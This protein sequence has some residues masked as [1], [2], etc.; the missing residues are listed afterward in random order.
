VSTATKNRLAKKRKISHNSG[1]KATLVASE[2]ARAAEELMANREAIKLTNALNAA[3]PLPV[4]KPGTSE[5]FSYHDDP[6]LTE[7]AEQHDA[8]ETLEELQAKIDRIQ[9]RRD[10][11]HPLDLPK[12][13][14]TSEQMEYIAE[15]LPAARWV[16]HGTHFEYHTGT[17]F[18]NMCQHYLAVAAMIDCATY[19]H[20][21]DSVDDSESS[22][23][24]DV[25]MDN[26]TGVKKDKVPIVST[27][28]AATLC[29][30]GEGK[31]PSTTNTFIA[32]DELVRSGETDSLAAAAL[33][34]V[35]APDAAVDSTF[36]H[37]SASD[38][39]EDPGC[40]DWRDTRTIDSLSSNGIKFVTIGRQKIL[41][42]HQR[43]HKVSTDDLGVSNNDCSCGPSLVCDLCE[44]A[45]AYIIVDD[46]H[47][48]HPVQI[49]EFLENGALVY[50]VHCCYEG[51]RGGLFTL[52]QCK[53]EI[54]Y[55][56]IADV[57]WLTSGRDSV[58]RCRENTDW[59]WGRS[60]KI[61][62]GAHLTWK[63]LAVAA[64]SYLFKF[65]L[66]E[67]PRAEAKPRDPFVD[68][69]Y[70][71]V[72]PIKNIKDIVD[73]TTQ[74]VLGR[75]TQLYSAGDSLCCR[76][77]DRY[78]YVPKEGIGHISLWATGRER[79]A[80]F[81]RDANNLAKQWLRATK[82][83]ECERADCVA[84]MVALGIYRN[85]GNEITALTELKP[86]T[87]ILEYNTK[88]AEPY[89][90]D[91]PRLLVALRRFLHRHQA[92]VKPAAAV[93]AAVSSVAFTMLVKAK[94]ASSIVTWLNTFGVMNRFVES[95]RES[96]I[97]RLIRHPIVDT[98]QNIVLPFL[99]GPWH[100][101]IRAVSLA[102]VAIPNLVKFHPF[103]RAR[104]ALLASF[105]RAAC[106]DLRYM[107]IAA[108][109]VTYE[110]ARARGLAH[111]YKRGRDYAHY[112]DLHTPAA[113]YPSL[114]GKT[115]RVLAVYLTSFV[116]SRYFPRFN[117]WCTKFFSKSK[118]T[119]VMQ[120]G[121][122]ITNYLLFAVVYLIT[123]L[124]SDFFTEKEP[125]A[126]VLWA[127]CARD[128]TLVEPR[129][130]A[131]FSVR[132]SDKVCVE[133][134]LVE[135]Q[136]VQG[137]FLIGL[138]IRNHQPV[139]AKHCIHNDL[140]A[141][142]NR[143]IC[144]RAPEQTDWWATVG[145]AEMTRL[146]GDI[147]PVM[148]TPIETWL[149][150]YPLKKREQ[151]EQALNEPN[152]D[153]D[154]D[155]C[156]RSAFTKTECAVKRISA[157]GD[158]QGIVTPFDPRL[159]QGCTPTYVV[160]TGPWAHALSKACAGEHCDITYGPG[161]NANQLDAWLQSAEASIPG[162]LA[163]CD[164][165]AVRLDASVTQECIRASNRLYR[166]LQCPR[167][168][169]R[170]F[171][172]DV[173][174]HG[175]TSNGVKYSV[176]GT[177]PSGKTTT[178]VGNTICVSTVVSQA[179]KRM[180]R[181]AIVAG[182]DAA[183]VV[184]LT[185][186]RLA[187]ERL[188]LTGARAGFE[189]KFKAS[190]RRYDME[191]CSGRW[192]PAD[193]PC[194]FAFGPKPGKLLPKLYWAAT[195]NVTGKSNSPYLHAVS[196]GVLPTVTH[197][198]VAREFV[199]TVLRLSSP[200][201]KLN[202]GAREALQQVHRVARRK[203][204][205]QSEE[206]WEAYRHIYDVGETECCEAID[207]LNTVT[208]LPHL[209]QHPIYDSFVAA[210][211]PPVGDPPARRYA[212][213]FTVI[214]DLALRVVYRKPTMTTQQRLLQCLKTA[215]AYAHVCVLGPLLEERLRRF[216]PMI[217]SAAFIAIEAT[218]HYSLGG[219]AQLASYFPT[220]CMH[221]VCGNYA[222][223][224]RRHNALFLHTYWN[225]VAFILQRWG[226]P[227]SVLKVVG[228]LVCASN[229]VEKLV[230][231]VRL[232]FSN[233]R[234]QTMTDVQIDIETP[235]VK[236]TKAPRRNRSG[237][238]RPPR[239]RQPRQAR[240]KAIFRAIA[241][242]ER[243]S[244]AT[245]TGGKQLLRANRRN[246]RNEYLQCLVDPENHPG[247]RYPDKFCKQ[248]ATYQG[249]VDFGIQCFKGNDGA[250]GTE[251]EPA[252]FFFSVLRPSIIH[253]VMAYI[254]TV[255]GVTAQGD[256][257]WMTVQVTEQSDDTG[258]F[259]VSQN[260]STDSASS[261]AM[262][263]TPTT[264][265]NLKGE[266]YWNDQDFSMPMFLGELTDV[267]VY[268][269]APWAT[270]NG[271]GNAKLLVVV[272]TDLIVDP[273]GGTDDFGLFVRA[274][275]PAGATSWVQMLGNYFSNPFSATSNTLNYSIMYANIT[276]SSLM[277]TVDDANYVIGQ[278]GIGI[279]F[280]Y[281]PNDSG[282]SYEQACTLTSVKITYE[283]STSDNPITSARFVPQDFQD[284]AELENIV[285]QYRCVSAS[286]WQQC[287][288]S[289][290]TNGGTITACSYKGGQSPM[291]L[292]MTNYVGISQIPEAYAGAFKLGT[293]SIW[294]PSNER[295][296]NFR[297]LNPV[298]IWDHPFI[299]GSGISESAGTSEI[300]TGLVKLRA[301]MN[302]E[303][304][305]KSRLT[306]QAQSPVAPWQID[307][308]NIVLAAREFKTSMENPLHWA[309][310]RN[311]LKKAVDWGKDASSWVGNNMSWIGPA[312]M[313]GAALL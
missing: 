4:V 74:A 297:N 204:V 49:A 3:Q 239:K 35:A 122:F 171:E 283:P 267:G 176:P 47:R 275:G 129:E 29:Q 271:A 73:V 278:P 254:P 169:M 279:Q 235:G 173:V 189:L 242:E 301:V 211:S 194:G 19:Y 123:Y 109:S 125:L 164:T 274:V 65:Y 50:S 5:D 217:M 231:S 181:K 273:S 269:G 175:A 302:Y 25:D 39:D 41:R 248:S 126:P 21:P 139:I 105:K 110:G 96:A 251:I 140:V 102:A 216:S 264:I 268:Y 265:Y 305:T 24:D 179:L 111:L 145:H 205:P 282:V 184:P 162:P 101:S 210:D 57:V 14:C 112:S 136:P 313:A 15:Q 266:F 66:T 119:V 299:V 186:M 258:I 261:A 163:Y 160:T 17:H 249:L 128:R 183:S 157:P 149:A 300:P 108:G 13:T 51:Q 28:T 43:H 38:D 8:C 75:V 227:A 141:V 288:A 12:P 54:T 193:T 62:R 45:T 148:S 233:T 200:D 295:D 220:A 165:D 196:L 31:D 270:Y 131:K 180:P 120:P 223:Q 222:R 161:L 262:I 214:Y 7:F 250:G 58:R 144:E 138:G 67:L 81:Q 192:W 172:A 152:S 263:L 229:P 70:G 76:V 48:Y 167:R 252:G 201:G 11:R 135:C 2:L 16:E 1:R 151:L 168:T 203:G 308:A 118:T 207:E 33:A 182:D 260:T 133:P 78:I 91:P 190:K 286:M 247:V 44:D 32:I 311:V 259:P 6:H 113:K 293:Y 56:R 92:L 253:P 86:T 195:R 228:S 170:L 93:G 130:G 166:R 63:V 221:I 257:A 69:F 303:F 124:V 280:Q 304:T 240:P 61:R 174:T 18:R 89:A 281:L 256:N 188:L 212:S 83:N 64:D 156:R 77:E 94:L 255:V 115:I 107:P 26:D 97:L 218:G 296:M 198:P 59:L 246:M 84:Y 60:V 213:V 306:A 134:Q 226:R 100:S 55:E 290:L 46:I 285:D 307:H 116:F 209:L 225:H 237:A 106:I 294:M 121:S 23:D 154:Y 150:R 36:D 272:C 79:N 85:M 177:V 82:L 98:L 291:Q 206:I 104:L 215:A 146:Y 292:G 232:L 178:T 159:I 202:S 143:G 287:T 127:Y 208:K 147:G 20:G 276:V 132:K 310:I 234:T 95:R 230:E 88:I 30:D 80:T 241:A 9:A 22:D 289:D 103:R 71:D 10:K 142:C 187:E 244:L 197:L 155:V 52:P 137:P 298:T 243:Q 245:K 158:D 185:N 114:A 27:V 90:P 117:D 68:T 53:P 40:L 153:G 312:A 238:A 42:V 219:L 284:Q 199:E 37:C 72:A 34:V 277:N 99:P 309:A 87:A 224:D 236:R 191:F